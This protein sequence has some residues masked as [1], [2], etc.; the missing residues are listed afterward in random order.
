MSNKESGCSKHAKSLGNICMKCFNKKLFYLK[1]N[2]V[3]GLHFEV[4]VRSCVL[5]T[6]KGLVTW[7]YK[8]H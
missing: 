8:S 4:R 1:C 5:K 6:R 7:L 2:I 3:N